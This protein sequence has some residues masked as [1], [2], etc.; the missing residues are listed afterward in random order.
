M[1]LPQTVTNVISEIES[2]GFQAY[3]VGGCVRDSLMG[4]SPSDWDLTTSAHPDDVIAIFGEKKTIPTGIRHGTVTV[5]AEGLPLEITTFRIDGKYEDNRHPTE[6]TFSSDITSDLMRRDFTVNAMAYNPKTGI[7]DPFGG[8]SDLTSGII[9]A[10]GNPESRFSEDAL[11][12]MR[13]IRFSGC[14]GFEIEPETEKALFKCKALLE[15]VAAERIMTEFNKLLVC[16][17]APLVLSKYFPVMTKRLL[18]DDIPIQANVSEIGGVFEPLSHVP[19]HLGLRLA[20]FLHGASKLYN[21]DA[22]QLAQSFLRRLKYDN[23]TK[24][25]VLSVLEN[26]SY[27][28]IPQRIPVRKAINHLGAETLDSLLTFKNALSHSPDSL[29]SVRS[30]FQEI[31]NDGDCCHIKNLAIDGATLANTFSL[32]GREIGEALKL[33]LDAVMED[34]CEN[35]KDTLQKFYRSVS[36]A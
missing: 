18:G 11:R 4:K 30:V 19:N 14:L 36:K 31:I 26:S 33:L 20:L 25:Q 13:A 34:R 17:N 16:R 6:V 21:R 2:S 27:E 32:S 9:R 23:R 12:I 1:T 22:S 10:V 29:D 35:K 7:V 8:A 28:L 3:A 5:I 15:N 24:K